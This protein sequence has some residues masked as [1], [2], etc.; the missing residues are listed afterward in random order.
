VAYV[1]AVRAFL[2][3]F[4]MGTDKEAIIDILIKHTPVKDRQ[5]YYTMMPSSFEPNGRVNV[6]YLRAEQALYARE[7]LLTDPVDVD[8]LVDHQYVEY[9][10]ARLGER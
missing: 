9:A 4:A 3:A 7:G 5:V 2:D 8:T 10:V 1:K 6:D